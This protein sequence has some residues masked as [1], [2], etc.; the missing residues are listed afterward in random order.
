[1]TTLL[2]QYQWVKDAVAGAE[3]RNR[4]AAAAMIA[5]RDVLNE[6]AATVNHAKRVQWAAWVFQHIDEAGLE[7]LPFLMANVVIAGAKNAASDGDI[8]YV[9]NSVID[10]VAAKFA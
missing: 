8:Q 1:M 10:V 6:D 4:A 7:L 2:E 9:V 3:L 5:A